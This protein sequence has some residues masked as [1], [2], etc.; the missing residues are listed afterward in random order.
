MQFT[1]ATHRHANIR[2]NKGTSLGVTQVKVP[3]QRSPYPSK[4]EDR[5]QE[6]T[7]RQEPCARADAWR[8]AKNT[9]RP[10][11]ITENRCAGFIFRINKNR[12]IRN[13]MRDYFQKSTVI[14]T[15]TL[16]GRFVFFITIDVC[17]NTWTTSIL[18]LRWSQMLLTHCDFSA[19]LRMSTWRE[20]QNKRGPTTGVT[21]NLFE[22]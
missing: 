19:V 22:G 8:M 12:D 14:D 4:F 1:K 7:E 17:F 16:R 2:E 11:M 15:N 9:I 5:S 10:D 13:L 21:M 20:I 18:F 3:H 6:E